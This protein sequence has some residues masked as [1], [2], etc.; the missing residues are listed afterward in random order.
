MKWCWRI[1][2]GSYER[3]KAGQDAVNAAQLSFS[4]SSR[5][6]LVTVVKSSLIELRY[7]QQP[8]FYKSNFYYCAA[9]AHVLPTILSGLVI[10]E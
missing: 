2:N 3:K 8:G 9:A 7:S 10:P 5:Y 6:R 4:A 1:G